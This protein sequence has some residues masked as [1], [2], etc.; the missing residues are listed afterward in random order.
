MM[1]KEYRASSRRLLTRKGY[2][3]VTAENGQRALDLLSKNPVDVILLDLKMPVMGEKSS[4]RPSACF[5]R[6]FLWS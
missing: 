4:F 2:D 5:T 3:V 6:I 1:K